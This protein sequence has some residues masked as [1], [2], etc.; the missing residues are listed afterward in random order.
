MQSNR[1]NSGLTQPQVKFKNQQHTT[2]TN[3]P[4]NKT[5]SGRLQTKN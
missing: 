3:Q 2:H 1:I 5:K 4:R